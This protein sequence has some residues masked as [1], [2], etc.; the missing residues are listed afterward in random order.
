[1]AETKVIPMTT[2]FKDEDHEDGG[3]VELEHY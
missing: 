1:M 3:N 2:M